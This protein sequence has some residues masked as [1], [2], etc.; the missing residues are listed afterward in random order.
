MKSHWKRD[1][2]IGLRALLLVLV[3]YYFPLFLWKG[4]VRT[5]YDDHYSLVEDNH[6]LRNLP[7]KIQTVTVTA[8]IPQESQNSLRRRTVRLCNELDAFLTK[9]W[10]RWSQT[11]RNQNDATNQQYKDFSIETEQ[12]YVNQFRQRALEIVKSLEAKG[13]DVGTIGAEFGAV[14]RAPTTDEI[15]HLRNLAWHLDAN[16]S[17]IHF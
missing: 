15:E 7:P 14:K 3:F 8:D 2:I 4:I 12:Q 16:D 11:P 10:E 1:G 9:R 17:V 5:V 13:L 6:R